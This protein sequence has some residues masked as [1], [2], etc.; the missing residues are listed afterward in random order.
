MRK[1]SAA[2]VGA[3]PTTRQSI[4]RI[5]KRDIVV[6]APFMREIADTVHPPKEPAKGRRISPH[7]GERDGNVRE[8]L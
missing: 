6:T 7:F 4:T 5:P 2:H 1:V 3:V 8:A